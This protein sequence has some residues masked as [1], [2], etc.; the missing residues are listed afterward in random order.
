[1]ST[2][3]PRRIKLSRA[4]GARLPEG[5]VSVARPNRFGNIFWPGQRVIAPGAWGA[6]ASPYH[7]CLLSGVHG[8]G[9][10][11]YEIRRVRDKADAVRLFASYVKAD[12]SGWPPADIRYSLGGRDLG[13]WCHEPEPGEPDICHGSVLL[14]LANG[15]EMPAWLAA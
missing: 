10:R 1:M 2:D 4:R 11:A 8:T 6:I 3:Q 12:P 13:C 7:G 14:S 5:A 9:A 15:W